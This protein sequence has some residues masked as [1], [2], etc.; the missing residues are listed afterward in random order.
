MRL[1][2]IPGRRSAFG[3]SYYYLLYA[4]LHH[5]P[6]AEVAGHEGGI[7]SCIVVASRE[8][9]AAQAVD[10]GVHEQVM[11]LHSLV[12]SPSYDPAVLD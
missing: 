6:G 4:E 7:K 3:L 11:L 9:G 12:S 2:K 5:R 1:H 8:P 10:L